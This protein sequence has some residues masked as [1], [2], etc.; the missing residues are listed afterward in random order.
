MLYCSQR[1]CERVETSQSRRGKGGL[2]TAFE[3]ISDSFNLM[4]TFTT[5]YHELS[6]SFFDNISLSRGD[7]DYS[8]TEKFSIAYQL[9]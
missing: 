4:W 9:S 8:Q 7:K 6:R 2:Q 3:S 5:D 1:P